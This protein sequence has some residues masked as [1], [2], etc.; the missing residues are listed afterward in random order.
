M[1]S[2]LEKD[3]FIAISKFHSLISLCHNCWDYIFRRRKEQI[4]NNI[5]SYY[6]MILTSQSNFLLAILLCPLGFPGGT[7][8]K[9]RP[10][11]AG[12]MRLRFDA[13]VRKI[14]WGEN[15]RPCQYPC[16]ENPSD[17]G[18]WQAIVH[19]DAKSQTWLRRLNVSTCGLE[20]AVKWNVLPPGIKA[21]PSGL[22]I[23]LTHEGK[24]WPSISLD[25]VD[26]MERPS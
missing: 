4:N 11:T 10:A 18:A 25:T 17:R 2:W 16:L 26:P 21:G 15:G 20:V 5:I 14:P 19:R 3:N 12:D 13:W 8:G 1:T 9:N 7:S 22:G 6:M 24:S 23:E